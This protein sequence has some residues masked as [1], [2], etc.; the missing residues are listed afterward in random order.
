MGEQANIFLADFY[1]EGKKTELNAIIGSHGY[2]E[3]FLPEQSAS[4]KYSIEIK[5]SVQ[6]MK[7]SE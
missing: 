2:V 5:E 1:Q 6:L 3:F 4:K 7:S